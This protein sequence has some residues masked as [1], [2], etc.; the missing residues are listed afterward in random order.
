MI[1]TLVSFCIAVWLAQAQV[2]TK[3]N[4]RYQTEEGRARMMGGLLSPDR[5]QQ[6]RPAELVAALGIKPGTTVADIGSGPGFLLPYLSRATGPKGRVIAEDIF[7][8]MLDK[9]KQKIAAE[10][11][12]NVT[13][14]L[15]T[16]DD[17]KLAE[18]VDLA[19]MLEVYHHVNYPDR[20][21]P[22]VRDSLRPGGRFIV[23][24]YYRRPEAMA[25]G[26]AIEHIRAD[27]DEFAR[28]IEASGFRLKET[29]DHIPGKMYVLVFEAGEKK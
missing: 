24:D 25:G 27:R 13:T 1:R 9:A 16:E 19:L 7:A 26:Y 8:D 6:Q 5:E 28:E 10:K 14:V 11:L 2:A 12:A 4:E 3:A 21:L 22:R 23:V 20:L 29:R 15:G 18:K 17:P